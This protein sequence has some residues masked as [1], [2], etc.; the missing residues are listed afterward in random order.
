[1]LSFL[2]AG[3]TLTACSTLAAA[4]EGP[5]AGNVG[6]STAAGTWTLKTAAK[7][8]LRERTTAIAVHHP[9]IMRK[10]R[11]VREDT[12]ATVQLELLIQ[13]HSF[14]KDQT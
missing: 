1:M 7:A 3:W 12:P 14:R 6:K 13:R 5:G 8:K 2:L 11:S 10:E 9:L 4:V